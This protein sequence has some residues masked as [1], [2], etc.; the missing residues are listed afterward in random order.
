MATAGSGLPS[1]IEPNQDRIEGVVDVGGS[2]SLVGRDM[3]ATLGYD[4]SARAGGA[5]AARERAPHQRD[6]AKRAALL[7]QAGEE[8]RTTAQKARLASIREQQASLAAQPLMRWLRTV[9]AEAR[10]E[11]MEEATSSDTAV[12]A[13]IATSS[14]TAVSA[15]IATSSDTAVSASTATSSDTAVSAGTATGAEEATGAGAAAGAGEAASAEAAAGAEEATSAEAAAGAEGAAS[16]NAAMDKPAKPPDRLN[17]QFAVTSAAS[18]QELKEPEE[19]GE[20]AQLKNPEKPG[21]PAELK[22]PGGPAQPKEPEE[23]GGPAE[24]KEP[25]EPEEDPG[26]DE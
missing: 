24:L 15:S 10:V 19:P 7:E 3:G 17:E 2:L 21:E 13:S 20:P 23:P 6:E 22:E 12:S 16:T 4:A 9:P 14:D 26:W 18:V 5:Q 11:P 25:E 8:K 1:T